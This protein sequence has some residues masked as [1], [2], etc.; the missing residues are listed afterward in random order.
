MPCFS[1]IGL[2]ANLEGLGSI[3]KPEELYNIIER[4]CNGRCASHGTGVVLTVRALVERGRCNGRY[5]PTRGWRLVTQ[6]LSSGSTQ[7]VCRQGW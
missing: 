3:E 7:L 1:W 6:W 2:K 4:F 5:T